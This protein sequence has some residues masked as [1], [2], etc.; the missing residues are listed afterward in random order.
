MKKLKIFFYLFVIILVIA[1]AGLAKL[2]FSLGSVIK[3]GIERI[4]PKVTGTTIT[5]EKVELAPLSGKGRIVNLVVGNPEGYNTASA[6]TLGEIRFE[7]DVKS[8]KGDSIIIREIYIDQPK[9]TYEVGLGNSNIT[10]IKNNV[11]AFTPYS[12]GSTDTDEGDGKSRAVLIESFVLSDAKI[13]LS[14][15]FLQGL[16]VDVALPSRTVKNIN[17]ASPAEAGAEILAVILDAVSTSVEQSG[18]LTKSGG[19]QA[20]N[21][22][23]GLKDAPG[24]I[25]N[26]TKG[27]KGL[28]G[29]DEE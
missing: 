19:A 10:T 4:G 16:Q 2:Y 1:I 22:T 17:S 18:E 21:L 3:S 24:G 13:G 9:I 20:K 29:K 6:F 12:D 7:I 25:R 27:I 23:E 15:K 14:A 28:F 11:E 5:A 26:V 8:L